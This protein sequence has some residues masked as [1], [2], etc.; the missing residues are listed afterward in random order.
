MPKPDFGV[1]NFSEMNSPN[2]YSGGPKT[3]NKAHCLLDS[4]NHGQ[5]DKSKK[6]A[7]RNHSMISA[8]NDWTRRKNALSDDML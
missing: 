7:R 1:K 2:R 6:P 4:G 3:M 5:K 8:S